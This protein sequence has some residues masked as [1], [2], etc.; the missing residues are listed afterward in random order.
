MIRLP[1]RLP[2]SAP[3]DDNYQAPVWLVGRHPSLAGLVTRVPGAVDTDG[4]LD[5]DVLGNTVRGFDA[6]RRAW[7]DY[8]KTTREPTDE[9]ALERWAS[10]GPLPD[11][12]GPR[13]AVAAL[14]VM[15]TAEA[16]RLRLLAT[17][18]LGRV[19]FFVSDLDGLDADGL[20]LIRDWCQILT[21]GAT[22]EDLDAVTA[23]FHA[24]DPGEQ[25]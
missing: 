1:K 20:R 6:Y 3:A 22:P 16:T 21:A 19:E 2:E 12:F 24:S 14:A 25:T 18:G 4:D 5:M 8:R 17:L 13:G 9:A 10:A 23:R 11:G 7:A 15:S